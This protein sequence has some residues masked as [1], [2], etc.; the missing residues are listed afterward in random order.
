[1]RLDRAVFA[2]CFLLVLDIPL[3]ADFPRDYTISTFLFFVMIVHRRR[4][5][6]IS[7]VC[8]AELIYVGISNLTGNL[9]NGA[10]FVE[11]HLGF[12]HSY[13][14]NIPKGGFT[15]LI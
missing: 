1:M 15:E 4:I 11:K 2:L 9:S 8:P 6:V 14:S 3:Q 12:L 5:P 13:I 10:L 7:F